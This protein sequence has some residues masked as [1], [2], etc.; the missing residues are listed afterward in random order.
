[1]LGDFAILSSMPVMILGF[2]PFWGGDGCGVCEK[3]G[4]QISEATTLFLQRPRAMKKLLY[5]ATVLGSRIYEHE[6]HCTQQLKMKIYGIPR[7]S[8][9]IYVT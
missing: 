3:H 9:G 7:N 6:R 5:L 2:P 8:S 1:M 4:L